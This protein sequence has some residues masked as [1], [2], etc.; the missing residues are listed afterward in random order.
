MVPIY[1]DYV[2]YT[3]PRWLRPTVVRL[4]SSIPET[5]QNGLA[6]IVLTNAARVAGRKSYRRQRKNRHALM[7]GGYHPRA[8]GSEPWIE[9]IAD[10]TISP[11]DRS[12]SF[13]QWARDIVVARVLFHE[14]GH[15]LHATIGSAERGGE[16]NQMSDC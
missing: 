10:R 12:L 14:L 7:V 16:P 8:K 3:P 4:L 11:A 5:Y 1:E 13:F 15:H 2:S 6:S 9:I